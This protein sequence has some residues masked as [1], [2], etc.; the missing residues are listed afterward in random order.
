M[1]QIKIVSGISH[2]PSHPESK[3]FR[4]EI[5]EKTDPSDKQVYEIGNHFLLQ[6]SDSTSPPSLP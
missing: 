1:F 3:A 5:H 2:L 4:E 6:I